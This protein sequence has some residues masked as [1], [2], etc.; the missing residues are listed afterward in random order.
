VSV[1]TLI[2]IDLR[3]KFFALLP[4][5][6]NHKF[7]PFGGALI[8]INDNQDREGPGHKGMRV[9]KDMNDLEAGHDE[10]VKSLA[11]RGES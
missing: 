11:T 6:D 4:W 5:K 8:R 3:N 1:P 7:P 2:R 10:F 9:L